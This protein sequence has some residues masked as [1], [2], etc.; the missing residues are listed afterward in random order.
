MIRSMTGFGRCESNTQDKKVLVEIKAVNHRYSDISIKL[1]RR[2]NFLENKVRNVL[3]EYVHRGKT[4]CYISYES[5]AEGN[6]RVNY[7]RE[8]A[9]EY[10]GYLKSMRE[11]FALGGGIDPTYVGRYPDVF[12]IEDAELDEEAVWAE[13]EQPLRDACAAFVSSRELEGEKLAEDMKKK[14][15]DMEKHVAYIEAES[16]RVIEEYKKKLTEKVAELAQTV[17]IDPQRIAMEVTI[18]ADKICVDEEIVRLKSHIEAT[19]KILEEENDVGRKLDFIVQEMN[20]EANTTLS[21][22]PSLGISNAGIELKTDIEKIR[23]QVQN[24]E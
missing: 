14:L 17:E 9:A 13:L 15:S 6:E 16:P 21:K 12:T 3:K 7:N 1:P 22:S 8:L 5:Y 19:R 23:E 24:I 2:L 4:D 10:I 18:Y 11:E 20:R